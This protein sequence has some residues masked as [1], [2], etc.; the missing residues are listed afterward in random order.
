MQRLFLCYFNVFSHDML[1]YSS[2]H[3]C[4]VGIFALSGDSHGQLLSSWVHITKSN[5]CTVFVSLRLLLALVP[6]HIHFVQIAINND[7]A[8]YGLCVVHH[9]S[10]VITLVWNIDTHSFL[11]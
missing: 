3:A 4:I 1:F 8:R 11:L 5:D 7:C 10:G 6:V 9:I 2:M